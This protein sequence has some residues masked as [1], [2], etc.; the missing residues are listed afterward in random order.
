MK[1]LLLLWAILNSPSLMV[2]PHISAAPSTITFLLTNIPKATKEACFVLDSGDSV[3]GSCRQ[4]DVDQF[5]LRIEYKNVIGGQY[6]AAA[7]LDGHV[8][9]V[10]MITVV[11]RNYEP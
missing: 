11:G 5:S 4:L 1:I 10:Q 3:Y 2:T 6:I 8:M 9:P 7:N